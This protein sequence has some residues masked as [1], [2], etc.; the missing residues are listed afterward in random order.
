MIENHMALQSRFARP[1]HQDMQTFNL[2]KRIFRRSRALLR[3]VAVAVV[4]LPAS[5]PA[6][7]PVAVP[8][9][10]GAEATGV[11]TSVPSEE[12]VY[13]SLGPDFVSN[14]DGGARQKFLRAE[15][16]IRV[17]TSVEPAIEYH[18]PAIRNR[19]VVLLS[20]QLEEHLTSTQG[21]ESLRAQALAEVRDVLR[22]F[23]SESH[24]A[25]V[26]DLFF[27]SFVIQG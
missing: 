5:L 2:L 4:L 22:T 27:T 17:H 19:I 18:L 24:A 3:A 11:G 16:V 25:W 14:Y 8:S 23:E 15:V 21:R 20:A 6:Q 7:P 12:L 26:T 10:G 9:E 1:I 13:V